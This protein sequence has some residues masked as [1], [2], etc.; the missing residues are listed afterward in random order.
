[1]APPV[2]ATESPPKSKSRGLVAFLRNDWQTFRKRFDKVRRWFRPRFMVADPRTLGLIR[3]VIG[4]L[5]CG[6]ALR[7]GYYTRDFYSNTGV[8]TNHWHLFSPDSEFNF[9]LFHAFSS[10]TEVYIAFGLAFCCFFLF[11]IG[12]RTRL[13]NVLSLVWIT[14]LDNRLVMVENGGYVVVNLI[15][16]WLC[17]LPTGTRFSVDSLRLAWRERRERSVE[18]LNEPWWPE[19]LTAPHHSLAS[20]MLVVNFGVIYVFN[21]VN[22]YGSTWRAGD[23]LHFVLHLDRMVT[24]IAVV[25]R[26]FLP[27]WAMMGLTWFV[28]VIEATIVMCI[29]WPRNRRWLRPIAMV[30]IVLLHAG[31]GLSMRLG[32][33][34]WFMIGW[35]MALWMAVHWSALEA[36]HARRHA[37]AVVVFDPQSGLGWNLARLIARLDATARV[38]F[39]DGAPR[40]AL[41]EV[42][43]AGT[44]LT[45]RRALW[46]LAAHVLVGGRLWIPLLRVAS[47][48]LADVVLAWLTARPTWADRFFGLSPPDGDPRRGTGLR[49]PSPFAERLVRYRRRARELGLAYFVLAATSQL[50]N[51]N[52]SIPEPIKHKQPAL[53]RASIVYPRLFQGWGMFAPNPIRVDGVV[54]IDAITVDGRH[55]DPLRGGSEPDLFLSDEEGC[56]LGQI[57]QD[58]MN[59]IRLDRNKRHRKALDRWLRAYHKRSGHAEDEIVFYN[60]YWLQDMN[61]EPGFTEP[62]LHKKLCIASWRKAGHRAN[63]GRLPSPCRVVSAGE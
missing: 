13:F 33:F 2:R 38:R 50:L 47:L 18:E 6:E 36:A 10:P 3:I 24:G 52:K 28:L 9:S 30:L 14:S 61:P 35:S 62:E 20:M 17:W 63:K 16:F 51:E 56:G 42:D 26:N 4:A 57:P 19:R 49:A 29:F 45:D 21:V 55:L 40:D 53:V 37:E 31:F 22:K 5:L 41:I 44:R 23:T 8:V 39:G 54:A 34:S 15:T 7:R 1:M 25:V 27:N 46:W 48:G 59:R 12:Y 58:Y 11:A 32:P 43:V 60:V